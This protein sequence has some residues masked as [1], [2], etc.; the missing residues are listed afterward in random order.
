M[1]ISGHKDVVD[2]FIKYGSNINQADKYGKTAL[3]LAAKYG[4]FKSKLIH[5][6]HFWNR[7]RS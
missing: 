1:P 2:L 5:L 7:N 6:K 3:H 4:I